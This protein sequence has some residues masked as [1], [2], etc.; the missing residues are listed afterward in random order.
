M[1]KPFATDFAA[2]SEAYYGTS[3]KKM[4]CQ[5]LLEAMLKDVGVRNNW[6]GSNHMYRD[7]AWVGTPEECKKKFGSIP[8][9]AWIYILEQ[10]G[11]EPEKYKRDGIGNASHVGVKIG[12]GKGAVHSSEKMGGVC[13]SAFKDKTIPNGG[14][15]RVG[16]CRLL[17]YG[18]KIETILYGTNDISEEN[19][20]STDEKEVVI[21]MSTAT[22]KT[23]GGILNIRDI[24]SSRGTDIGD[25]PNGA[26]V[27]VIEKTSSDWW[28]IVYSGVTGYCAAEY[29][30]EVK[31]VELT[32]TMDTA[33]ALYRALDAVIVD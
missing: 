22:V 7:M 16:L 21:T 4:D 17:D 3:Y 12:S 31:T 2:K 33:V 28:K 8:V 29:L 24:P 9:G 13:E 25:I 18:T 27:E 26:T 10:D 15:N 14:W 11:G 1:S 5:A 6:T 23:S 20:V 32:L 30:E 19:E